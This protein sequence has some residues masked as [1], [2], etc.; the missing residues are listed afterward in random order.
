MKVSPLL[1]KKVV[2]QSLYCGRPQSLYCGRAQW[3]IVTFVSKYFIVTLRLVSCERN[4]STC[5]WTS[6]KIIVALDYGV[7]FYSLLLYSFKHVKEYWNIAY[8][9]TLQNLYYR[10]NRSNKTLRLPFN[11]LFNKYW[12]HRSTRLNKLFMLKK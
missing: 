4:N 1:M 10:L 2:P 3:F 12:F 11:E 9:K 8:I 5:I 6:D 7:V